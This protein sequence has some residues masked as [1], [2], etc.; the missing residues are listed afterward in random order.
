VQRALA[1][2]LLTG[3]PT[4]GI[5]PGSECMSVAQASLQFVGRTYR[6]TREMT[7]STIDCSTLVSQSLWVGGGVAVPFI[8][9]S[10]RRFPAGE[11]VGLAELLPGDALFAYAALEDTPDGSHNHVALFLGWDEIGEPWGIES[12]SPHGVR[13]SR[14]ADLSLDGGIKRFCPKPTQVFAAGGWNWVAERVPKLGRLGARLT[15]GGGRERHTGIDVFLPAGTPVLAPL[16]GTL[17]SDSEISRGRVRIVGDDTLCILANV[18]IEADAEVRRGDVLGAVAEQGT[19]RC[20]RVGRASKSWLHVELWSTRD[21]GFPHHPD[22]EVARH[23]PVGQAW[24][25]AAPYN[26]VY[27]MKVGEIGTLIPDTDSG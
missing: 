14:L 22:G 17:V 19:G 5:F 16:D 7:A 18:D 24:R 4:R 11:S 1:K 3:I 15:A 13:L 27:A 8:A 10:Q 25:E 20:N 26:S 6:I 12:K 2:S 9:E 21:I 23:R